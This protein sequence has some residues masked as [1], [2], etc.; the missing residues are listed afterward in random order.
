MS[1]PGLTVP[2]GLININDNF[3]EYNVD[4]DLPP[5][6]WIVHGDADLWVGKQSMYYA[7]C[8]MEK[9]YKTSDEP[10]VIKTVV[11]EMVIHYDS[12][13][14]YNMIA[15]TFQDVIANIMGSCNRLVGNIRVYRKGTKYKC[16]KTF[17][18]VKSTDLFNMYQSI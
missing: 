3:L 16:P 15:K 6:P 1:L 13:L 4:T 17:T 9:T 2:M 7:K 8:K 12:L 5:T 11:I 10:D 14:P 18:L